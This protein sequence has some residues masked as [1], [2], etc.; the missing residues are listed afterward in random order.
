M[1]QFQTMGAK[2]TQCNRSVVDS[3]NVVVLAVKPNIVRK[4]LRDVYPAVTNDH[5]ILSLAAGI[6]LDTLQE[7][8]AIQD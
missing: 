6:S 5:L 8:A 3:N 4:I 2:T 1:L 7:V